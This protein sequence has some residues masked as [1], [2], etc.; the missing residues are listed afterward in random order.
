MAEI[1]SECLDRCRWFLSYALAPGPQQGRKP[2]LLLRDRF[3][4]SDGQAAAIVRR[5]TKEGVIE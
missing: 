2:F 3:L 5:L 4:L 1:D